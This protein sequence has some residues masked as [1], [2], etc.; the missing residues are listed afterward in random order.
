MMTPGSRDQSR[1]RD[2]S[3]Q[4]PEED[5]YFYKPELKVKNTAPERR[6]K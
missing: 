6:R 1:Q 4:P 2:I 5:E 3:K